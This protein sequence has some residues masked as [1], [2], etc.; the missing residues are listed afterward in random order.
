MIMKTPRS[1]EQ[2]VVFGEDHNLVGIFRNTSGADSEKRFAVILVT[3]G[4]LPS[5]GPFRMHVDIARALSS[6]SIP[7]LR[8]DLSGIGESLPGNFDGSSLQR[9]ASEI[10]SAIDWLQ[11]EH[12]VD[13]VALFGLC[14]G[15]DD[16]LFAALNDERIISLFSMDGLGYRTTKYH[17]YRAWNH[18]VPKILSL[19]KW[20]QLLRS[21]LG[22]GAITPASLEMGFDIREFPQRDEAAEQLQQLEERGIK[23]HFHYT[24]GVADYYNYDGQFRDM[25]PELEMEY[26]S[27]SFAPECDHT[28]F[29]CEH[30]T[31][32]VRR[33]TRFFHEVVQSL[34]PIVPPSEDVAIMPA[35]DA[36]VH[37]ALPTA[38]IL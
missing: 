13:R 4:V 14:S 8:F 27:S 30:R 18:Y 11:Q 20:G 19:S 21:S 6:A 28:A 25:F 15:A 24:G 7:S 3:P 26:I 36:C 35:M 10:T 5:A 17:F 12:A 32:L 23:A 1:R 22:L 37:S 38:S 9:A 16:A 29:L 31:D 2:A 33:V 34:E